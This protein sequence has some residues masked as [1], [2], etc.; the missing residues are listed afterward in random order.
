[1]SRRVEINVPGILARPSKPDDWTDRA[2]TV[3]HLRGN[4]RA[5]KFEHFSGIL[6]RAFFQEKRARALALLCDEYLQEGWKVSL[7]GHS[8][9]CDV[10]CRA[11][12]HVKYGTIST[13]QL[14]GA[15]C[16][17]SFVNNGL[18]LHLRIGTVQKVLIHASPDDKALWLARFTHP[19]L[20]RIGNG[21]GSL[22]FSGPLQV[23]GE[24]AHRVRTFWHVGF[25]HSDY[26]RANC[27]EYLIDTME[28]VQDD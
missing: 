10:I 7:R 13:I 1:M 9:G 24:I 15:A 5:E 12:N 19:V 20:N 27:L 23:Q 21:Y 2:V 28:D 14:V 6:S 8:N 25:R 11:L 17:A 3:A 22:G 26:F 18:N 16:E 4:V